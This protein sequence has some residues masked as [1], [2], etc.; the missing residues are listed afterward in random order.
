[1]SFLGSKEDAKKYGNEATLV[2]DGETKTSPVRDGGTE[3][4]GAPI[5]GTLEFTQTRTRTGIHDT[6]K[7]VR[8]QYG[9]DKAT[10]YK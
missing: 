10:S 6:Q 8:R 9:Q 5:G 7:T 3:A 4:G 1:M 2:I